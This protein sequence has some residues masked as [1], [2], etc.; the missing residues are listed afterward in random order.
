MTRGIYVPVLAAG[1]FAPPSPSG[2]AGG[3]PRTAGTRTADT[4][5]SAG[6]PPPGPPTERPDQA[7]NQPSLHL[8]RTT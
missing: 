5:N 4:R 6:G 3:Q 1:L 7:S 2:R 8:K